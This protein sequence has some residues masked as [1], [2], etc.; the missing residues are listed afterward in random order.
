MRPVQQVVVDSG[1]ESE[2]NH[3]FVPGAAQHIKE[4]NSTLFERQ[5]LPLRFCVLF[6]GIIGHFFLSMCQKEGA[7][8]NDFEK[9]F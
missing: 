9:S 5:T 6:L 4:K 7:A 1:Y 3:L 8:S 2:E